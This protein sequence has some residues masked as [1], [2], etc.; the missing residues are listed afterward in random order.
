ME[1]LT[2]AQMKRVDEETINRFCPGLEL[3]ERAGC[4]VAEFILETFNNNGGVKAVIFAGAGNNGGDALVA[5]RYLAEEG[6]ECS[7]HMLKPLKNHSMDALK[8]LQRLEKLSKRIRNLREVGTERSD[9]PDIAAKDLADA[10]LIVDGLFGTGVK[11]PLRGRAKEA[12]EMMNS[13]WAPV[14]SID[15]PSGV[16]GDNG[17]IPGTAVKAD[18]TVTVGRPKLGLLFHPGRAHTGEMVVADIGF[19]QEVVDANSAGI[20][21]LDGGEAARRLPVRPGDAHKY[22]CGSLL[23]L[24]GSRQYTGA[25]MLA[26]EAALRGGCGMVFA[27]V[28]ESIKPIVQGEV[29]E[30]VVIAL[31]ET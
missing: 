15:V 8:N 14:I 9:W 5:A 31:P 10:T 3:M 30:A 2:S 20:F 29:S 13:A 11:G 19:P 7:V 4:K 6:C 24:A 23:L 12:V 21:M 17:T 22:Q 27:A 18:Y 16:D 1:I 26:A 28:P 25:A